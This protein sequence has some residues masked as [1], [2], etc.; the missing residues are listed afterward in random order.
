MKKVDMQNHRTTNM[1]KKCLKRKRKEKST[2]RKKYKPSSKPL[3]PA[4]IHSLKNESTP[5][6]YFTGLNGL[7]GKR[8]VFISPEKISFSHGKIV[9]VQSG[10]VS[11]FVLNQNG[12][13]YGRGINENGELGLGD[14]NPR[15]EWTF[16]RSQVKH[17]SLLGSHTLIIDTKDQVWG[18]GINWNNEV[19]P[20]SPSNPI[21]NPQLHFVS[22]PFHKRVKKVVA[23]YYRFSFVLCEDNHLFGF[24]CNRQ[25]Q[26]VRFIKFVYF[27]RD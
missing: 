13:L 8:D 11:A 26:L 15:S 5:K 27:F 1:Y 10:L 21:L 22:I 25:G 2:P 14:T 18:C 24:G 9:E 20:A 3:P 17:V 16:V 23:A 7:F 19:C 4:F 6:M 12:D